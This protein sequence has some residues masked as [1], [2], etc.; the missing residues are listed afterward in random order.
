VNR[1]ASRNFR[2]ELGAL[3]T[4]TFSLWC[5]RPAAAAAT[6]A[7][8]AATAAAAAAAGAGAGAGVVVLV[9]DD[10]SVVQFVEL[11][12]FTPALFLLAITAAVAATGPA[13][14][15]VFKHRGAL[16]VCIRLDCSPPAVCCYGFGILLVDICSVCK[17][18]VH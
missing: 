4:S 5:C 8:A 15:V 12:S 14:E 17:M 13:L 18:G 3:G 6:A 2:T 9:A 1:L 11:Q 7:A 16:V 10:A